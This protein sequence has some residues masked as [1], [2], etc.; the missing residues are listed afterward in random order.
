L[1]Y[2]PQ[3]GG[4]HVITASYP[5]DEGVFGG[6]GLEPS[7][8]SARIEAGAHPTTTTVSCRPIDVG[9][10]GVSCTVTV[11]DT[12]ATTPSPPSSG[13]SFS[14]SGTTAPFATC[15]LIATTS[16]ASACS[17][18]F[19]PSTPGN[20]LI[21]ARY[22]GDPFHL[23]SEGN[24]QAT[25]AEVTSTVFAYV[26]NDES[27][28]VSVINTAT[29]RLESVPDGAAIKVGGSPVSVA[30]TP[31]GTRAYVAN[32]ALGVSVIDTATNTVEALLRVPA[33]PF[34]IAISPDGSRAYVANLGAEEV[35]VIDTATNT[36]DARIKLGG[37]PQ[38][39]AIT[40]DGTRAYVGNQ[41]FGVQ[42]I[43]TTTNTV[44]A[45]PDGTAIKVGAGP[46]SIAITPDGA[47]AYVANAG[48]GT[49]SVVNTA[50]N[51][52]E[53]S[54]IPVGGEPTGVAIT[55]DGT[56]AYVAN[57]DS[58]A[59]SVINTTTNAV[60]AVIEVGGAPEAVAIGPDG[61]RAYVA[62]PALGVSVINTATN[63]VEGGPIAVGAGPFSIAISPVQPAAALVAPPLL[64]ATPRVENSNLASRLPTKAARKRM[65]FRRRPSRR[66]RSRG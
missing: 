49:V 23:A 13:V 38:S 31:D 56:R 6:P 27:G 54:A 29:N 42:V 30:I 3:A 10:E 53:R 32:S 47:R 24:V 48:D 59:I 60:E 16:N 61:S 8:A 41:A 35:S 2:T 39:V 55:P 52:V 50:T 37:G 58:G 40:P 34:G 64:N 1:T 45:V 20:Y 51:T 33:G 14:A 22:G 25:V 36:V 9:R 17:V 46:F 18:A 66:R 11:V 5:G 19:R 15:S 65:T 4:A 26:A 57:R 21:T 44:E 63:T 7:E 43:K 62:N 12:S 28:D